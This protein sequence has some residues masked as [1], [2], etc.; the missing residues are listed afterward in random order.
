MPSVQ[1]TPR[2][3]IDRLR[4]ELAEANWW[5]VMLRQ[6]PALEVAADGAPPWSKAMEAVWHERVRQEH[7]ECFTPGYD[8][9][10]VKGEMSRA[11][12]SYA[13]N[14]SVYVAMLAGGASQ[15]QVDRASA[16]ASV[17]GTWPWPKAAWKPRDP[18]RNLVRAAALLIAEI[19]RLD[20]AE[21]RR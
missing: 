9:N 13:I 2:E 12:A 14:A 11:A 6:R 16:A 3:T 17:P 15:D 20:R 8:D 19:E 18:R 10:Y 1:E 7:V 21:G 5:I 4:A